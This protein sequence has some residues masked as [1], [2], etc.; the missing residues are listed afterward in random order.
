MNR[1]PFETSG[2]IVTPEWLPRP[3]LIGCNRS[4]NRYLRTAWRVTFPDQTWCRVG[5]KQM[6][7]WYAAT[8][9]RGHMA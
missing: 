6:A 5:T 1:K 9:I 4:V 2:C 8:N 7:K 3:I